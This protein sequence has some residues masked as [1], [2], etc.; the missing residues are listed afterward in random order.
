MVKGSRVGFEKSKGVDKIVGSVALKARPPCKRNVCFGG[1]KKLT[2]RA[3][4]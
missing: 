1:Q 3:D 4:R 2:K